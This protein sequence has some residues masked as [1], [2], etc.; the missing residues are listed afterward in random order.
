MDNWTIPFKGV[1]YSVRTLDIRSIPSWEDECY[2]SVN[3]ADKA[4][5]DAYGE[6]P[7]DSEATAIDEKIFFYVENIENYNEKELLKH[8]EENL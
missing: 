3:V 7:W 2:G 5:E 4:L 6:E 8:L 1:D